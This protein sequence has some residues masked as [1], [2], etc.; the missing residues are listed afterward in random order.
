M[1]LAH[2]SDCFAYDLSFKFMQFLL[3]WRDVVAVINNREKMVFW[4][5]L[6]P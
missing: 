2:D 4:N 5:I 3:N 1:E 6:S